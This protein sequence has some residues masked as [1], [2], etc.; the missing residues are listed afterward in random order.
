MTASTKTATNALGIKA[1]LDALAVAARRGIEEMRIEDKRTACLD[2]FPRG[3][4]GVASELLGRI[5]LER[6]G[7]TGTYVCGDGHPA[8]EP[9]HSHAWV[10]VEGFIVDITHDQFADTGLD[11]WVFEESPWHTKF[12]RERN[13]LCLN[14]ADWGSYPLAVYSAMRRSCERV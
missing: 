1:Q 5:I 3:A 6:T 9:Q 10:E 8:L 11:G 4:C 14:P 7:F 2:S 12:R 13:L